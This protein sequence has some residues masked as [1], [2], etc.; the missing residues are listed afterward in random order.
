M[1]S[2][3][4][5]NKACLPADAV[6]RVGPAQDYATLGEA[7]RSFAAEAPSGESGIPRPTSMEIFGQ[8]APA[9]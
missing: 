1:G 6:V 2:A 9:T 5:F 7:I 4:T 3:A 8:A